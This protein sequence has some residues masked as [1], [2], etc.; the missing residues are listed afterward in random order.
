M[1]LNIDKT[2]LKIS[3]HSSHKYMIAS[4]QDRSNVTQHMKD[5]KISEYILCSAAVE[6]ISRNAANA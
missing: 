5:V 3:T 4:M 1:S 2:G 6:L